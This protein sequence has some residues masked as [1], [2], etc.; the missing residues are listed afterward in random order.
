MFKVLSYA[1]RLQIAD[2]WAKLV[3]LA[4]AS[5]A[6]E[7][8]DIVLDVRMASVASGITTENGVMEKVEHLVGIGVLYRC[9][10]EFR[11]KK[12][13]GIHQN[14]EGRELR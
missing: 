2:P 1:V 6:T 4:M 8:D 5:N 14:L 3:L 9:G 11:G 12:C 7:F 10:S 13:F